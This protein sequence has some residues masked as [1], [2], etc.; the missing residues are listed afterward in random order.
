MKQGLSWL[1][2]IGL[3]AG[4]GSGSNNN[5]PSFGPQ[6]ANVLS[7]TVGGS[8]LCAGSGSVSV[9]D[10]PCVKITLCQPGTTKCQTVP[11]ILVDTGSVGLRIFN[12]A[13]SSSISL[14]YTSGTTGTTIAQCAL[15]ADLS[16]IWGPVQIADIILGGEPPVRVPIQVIDSTFISG[17]IPQTQCGAGGVNLITS[18]GTNG[19]Q[20]SANGILGLDS[21]Q[22]DP[23]YYYACTIGNNSC[24]PYIPPAI[25]QYPVQ[26][27]VFLLPSDYNGISLLFPAVADNGVRSLTGALVLGIGTAS[28][29]GIASGVSLYPVDPNYGNFLTTYGTTS[30]IQ[31]T[32]YIDSG[33]NALGIPDQTITQCTNNPQ[34]YF[35]PSSTISLSATNRASGNVPQMISFRIA[36]E[37]ALSATGNLVFDDLGFFTS[38]NPSNSIFIWGFPFFLGRTVYF[39][40]QGQSTPLGPGPFYAF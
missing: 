16:V 25:P 20:L 7:V 5:L 1:L 38:S 35:C 23:G 36:N 15:F 9:P 17:A 22:I 3:A 33:T 21:F 24:S 12:S 18:P 26:N 40:Y 4:C 19:N 14:P 34:P 39:G 30:S 29:N 13:I 28:N 8:G 10:A 11:D 6:G 37:I 31:Y 2:V 32:A 27:P